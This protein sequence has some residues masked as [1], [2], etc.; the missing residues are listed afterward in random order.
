LL[1]RLRF[2]GSA[3]VAL[4]VVKDI[5]VVLADFALRLWAGAA[6]LRQTLLR[7]RE[8]LVPPG[9]VPV[10]HLAGLAAIWPECVRASGWGV[11]E[12]AGAAGDGAVADRHFELS[13]Q[14]KEKLLLGWM[15]MLGRV[16]AGF[17]SQ[18]MQYDAAA[19]LLRS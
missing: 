13:F 11:G 9:R 3:P 19:T 7:Y 8:A 2:A 12:G 15:V 5:V 4:V 1:C 16:K 6:F 18:H 14:Y 17:D 10:Q